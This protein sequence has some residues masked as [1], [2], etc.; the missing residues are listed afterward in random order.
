MT[1]IVDK[2]IVGRQYDS[3]IKLDESDKAKIIKLRKSDPTTWSY[4]V[5]AREFGVSHSRII[6][7][8]RP[9]LAEKKRL[10]F[11]ERRKDG[12]Y[13]DR[14]KNKIYMRKHRAYKRNLLE[15]NQLTNMKGGER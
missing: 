2:Y 1:S 13:Y 9:E 14:D 8:C 4:R 6:Q 5:L 10:Q 12:R 11:K 7:I 15:H 3:R